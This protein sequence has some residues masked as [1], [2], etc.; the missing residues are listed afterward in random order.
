MQIERF[1]IVS[2]RGSGVQ[3]SKLAVAA[4]FPNWGVTTG[5]F[6]SFNTRPQIMMLMDRKRMVVLSIES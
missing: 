6:L 2:M 4:I 5:H 1:S 3:I